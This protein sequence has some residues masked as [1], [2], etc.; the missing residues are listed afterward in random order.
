M[1]IRFSIILIFS[2]SILW[3]QHDTSRTVTDTYH[4]SVDDISN[5]KMNFEYGFGKL[6]I[7]PLKETKAILGSLTYNPTQTVPKVDYKKS[8][9]S[10]TLTVEVNNPGLDNGTKTHINFNLKHLEF[11]SKDNR[12]KSEI[13]F[14]LPTALPSR[15]NLD[16]GLGDADLDLSGIA[17]RGLRIDCGLSD[18]DIFFGK[19]NQ[20]ICDS[21]TLSNGLGDLRAEGLGFANAKRLDLE[22]GLGSA[23]I[24]LRGQTR[25]NMDIDAQV[26]LG[27]LNLI[28]PE[29]VNIRIEVG[30]SFLSSVDIS[31]LRSREE[32]IYTSP[33]W[34]SGRP[35]I[36]I[37]LQVDLGSADVYIRP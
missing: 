36:T 30:K 27:T 3:A 6:T 12:I 25:S 11:D 18:V 16:F 15:L 19:P 5:L 14:V 37:E 10:G 33:E 29:N 26:G 22:V 13:D 9:D 21:I 17:L 32:N 2:W 20:V 1:I 23:Y 35:T 4:Y 8:G 31:G 24:D 28:L 34:K 7:K